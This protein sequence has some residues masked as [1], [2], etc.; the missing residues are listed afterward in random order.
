MARWVRSNQR[1]LEAWSSHRGE[2]TPPWSRHSHRKEGT[3][4]AAHWSKHFSPAAIHSR[5]T[6]LH[7][8]DPTKDKGLRTKTA[9]WTRSYQMQ[10]VQSCGDGKGHLHIHDA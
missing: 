7:K 4:V 10:P 8:T 1:G 6:T 5:P 2:F 9:D 3:A